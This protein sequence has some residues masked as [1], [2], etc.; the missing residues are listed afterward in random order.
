MAVALPR[1]FGAHLR[2]LREAAGYTQEELAVIAGLSVHAISALERSER[3]RPHV[4]TVRALS[5][6]LGLGPA[7]RDAFV[8]SSRIAIADAAVDE[9]GGVPLPIPPTDLVGREDDVRALREWLADPGSRLITLVGPGG[10]GKS[11]LALEI[12]RAVSDDGASRAF[13]VPLAAI[14]DAGMA[15]CAIA[16]ALGFADVNASDLPARARA[17]CAGRPTLLVLDNFEQVL[18]AAPVVSSLV[19]SVPSL[20][21]I[22]TSRTP[23]RVRGERE[24]ALGPLALSAVAGESG[25][26]AGVP[27][28]RLFVERARSVQRDFQ[29]TPSNGDT[30]LA[31]CRRLDA[32]P[33]ALEL[34]ARWIKVLPPDELLRRLERNVLLSP[35]GPRDLP[36]RQQTMTATV[37]WSYDL[38]DP[39]EQ[40]ALQR[41]SVLPGRFP[42]EA[43]GWALLGR[44]SGEAPVDALPVLTALLDKSLLTVTPPVAGRPLYQMFETVRAYAADRLTAAG[45]RED[46]VE[47]LVRYCLAEAPRAEAGL[48]GPD[49]VEWLERVHQDLDNYR[50]VLTWLVERDRATEASEVAWGLITFWMIRG[51]SAEA[52][53]WLAQIQ[54]LPSV[55]PIARARSRIGAAMMW[56]WQGRQDRARHSIE[57]VMTDAAA[58]PGLAAVATL[59]VGHTR[60]ADGEVA[61]AREDFAR[62]LELFRS[63]SVPWAIGNALTGLAG[64]A[65]A[66]GDAEQAERLLDEATGVLRRAG[67]WYLSLVLYWRAVLA[68]RRGRADHA[69]ACVRESLTRVRAL[70]DKFVFVHMMTPLAAA[71]ALRGDFEWAARILG[72]QHDVTERSGPMFLDHA[73]ADLRGQI[74]REARERLGD[75]RFAAAFAAGGTCSIDELLDDIDRATE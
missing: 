66:S 75:A 44:N 33:L 58:D 23:L 34:T 12:A 63:A 10:V 6:A 37:G 5:A 46:A 20:Q 35:P 53:D 68:V 64:V 51:Q 15:A 19:S 30:V 13:F 50:E 67:P 24:Y 27:A 56:Y 70:H 22:V 48:V 25:D 39:Q 3:R 55:S 73:V 57:Q 11:R 7:A 47:G 1:S 9:L 43:A 29:L 2:H 60:Y 8:A 41:V 28:V 61:I 69:L 40:L 74:E 72:V 45:T 52:L 65:L 42:A 36:E 49:Q 31:I 54:E 21:L 59:V 71:A 17:A 4:D 38:L 14:R 62:S 26:L 16:E 18:V 32:L